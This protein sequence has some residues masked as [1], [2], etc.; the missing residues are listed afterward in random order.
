MRRWSCLVDHHSLQFHADQLVDGHV[1]SDFIG[2]FVKIQVPGGIFSLHKASVDLNAIREVVV[3]LHLSDLVHLEMRPIF[4]TDKPSSKG[5][6][7]AWPWRRK[8]AVGLAFFN[9]LLNGTRIAS[10][11]WELCLLIRWT[12]ISTGMW[13]FSDS[14]SRL[15]LTFLQGCT[16]SLLAS[17]VSS[18][19]TF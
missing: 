18:V 4:S 19:L 5:N 8:S 14:K 12:W 6:S 2:Q 16:F 3:T 9:R 7:C 13:Y 15:L 17:S 11:F 1:G 10:S